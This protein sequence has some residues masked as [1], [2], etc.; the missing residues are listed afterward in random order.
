MQEMPKGR[1]EKHRARA[2]RAC[3]KAK[4]EEPTWE[5]EWNATRLRANF[6]GDNGK[7]YMVYCPKCFKENYAPVVATGKCAWCGHDGNERHD[8]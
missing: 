5:E 3:L 4:E 1:T 8:V 6:I 2:V 7:F